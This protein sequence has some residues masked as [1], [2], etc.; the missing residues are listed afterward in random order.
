MAPAFVSHL[1]QGTLPMKRQQNITS[2][3]FWAIAAT[4]TFVTLTLIGLAVGSTIHHYYPKHELAECLTHSVVVSW[5]I[6][7]FPLA[8]YKAIK[9]LPRL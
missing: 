1:T 9:E 6:T 2:A 3:Q 8:L 5:L 7:L 4:F